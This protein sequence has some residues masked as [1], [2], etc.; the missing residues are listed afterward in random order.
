M[1]HPE[2]HFYRRALASSVA[3]KEAGDLLRSDIQVERF[4]SGELT[5]ALSKLVRFDDAS[6]WHGYPVPGAGGPA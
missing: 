5:E 6:V 4:D 1:R 3:A 2:K